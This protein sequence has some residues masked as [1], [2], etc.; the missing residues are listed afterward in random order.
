MAESLRSS[1]PRKYFTK[2]HGKFPDN[3]VHKNGLR[4]WLTLAR[5]K[6]RILNLKT[7]CKKTSEELPLTWKDYSGWFLKPSPIGPNGGTS[8]FIRNWVRNICK[9]WTPLFTN[10]ITENIKRSSC[11]KWSWFVCWLTPFHSVGR[12]RTVCISV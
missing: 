7:E 3:V 6:F 5:I 10:S 11:T 2:H 4:I 8:F 12:I 9:G 1:T